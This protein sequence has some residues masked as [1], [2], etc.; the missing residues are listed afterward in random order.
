MSEEPSITIIEN[1]PYVVKGDVPLSEDALVRAP[2]GDHLQYNHVKDYNMDGTTYHLCRCGG[3]S[4]KPFCDGTH[5]K[6]GFDG[7]ET[8]SR[9]PYDERVRVFEG[10]GLDLYDD[11]RC[12]FARLCHRRAGDAWAMTRGAESDEQEIVASSWHC[13][14]GRLEH[15]DTD[16]G[17]VYEQSFDPSIV[18]L[19]DPEKH[20]SGPLFV[21]GGI[22]LI[23]ADGHEYEKRNRYALCRCGA[24][25]NKPFCDAEHARIGFND[26]SKALEGEWGERDE[27]FDKLPDVH[28][29]EA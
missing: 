25:S 10:D 13:P 6:I 3:S 20:V 24:S 1:G 22:P 16:T 21:R 23:G 5:A 14:A 9:E 29:S 15:R 17:E 27:S 7:S 18:I 2:E 26:G 28:R 12:A 4:H 19:E 11:N 8:A